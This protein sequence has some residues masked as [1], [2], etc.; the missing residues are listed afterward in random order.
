[1]Q[2]MRELLAEAEKVEF[3]STPSTLLADA[4]REYNANQPRLIE[5]RDNH[6]VQQAVLW[7]R[8]GDQMVGSETYK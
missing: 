1:M 2:S 5:E 4:V 7:A 6:A 8:F 3:I